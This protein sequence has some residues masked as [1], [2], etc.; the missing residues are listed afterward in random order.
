MKKSEWED[1][2]RGYP[3]PGAGLRIGF[4]GTL[5]LLALLLGILAAMGV[6]GD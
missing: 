5:W 1:S 2:F 4:W 6:F 3:P